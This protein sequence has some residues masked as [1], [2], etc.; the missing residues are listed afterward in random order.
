MLPGQQ[1]IWQ[2]R[3]ELRKEIAERLRRE[4]AIGDPSLIVEHDL[5]D[6]RLIDAV[7]INNFRQWSGHDDAGWHCSLKTIAGYRTNSGNDTG[8]AVHFEW[9]G[10]DGRSRTT[11]RTPS[12][13]DNRRND[14]KRE[15]GLHE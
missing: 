8:W 11:S 7:F 13:A 15:W 4:R 1:P 9:T 12:E 14:A 6:H 3:R 2:R 10:S 5:T